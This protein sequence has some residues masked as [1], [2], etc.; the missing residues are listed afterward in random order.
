MSKILTK[1]V[2]KATLW[3]VITA[4]ILAVAVVIGCLFGFNKSATVSNSR[5]MTITVEQ[6]GFYN[7]DLREEIEEQCEKVFKKL[8]MDFTYE[9]KGEMSGDSELVYMFKKSVSATKFATA[10]DSLQEIFDT[11]YQTQGDKLEAIEVDVMGNADVE[12]IA[13][14]EK[15]FLLRGVIAGVIFAVLAFAYVSLRF[16]L[17]MGILTAGSILV[18]MALTT[19]LAVI[20]RIPVTYSAIA[21][22]AVSA[23]VTAALVLL[24]L[25]KLR[26]KAKEATADAEEALLANAPEKE[27]LTVAACGGIALVVMG[28][29]A[30]TTVRWFAVLALLG[31]IASV[32]VSL[33]FAPSVYLPL[34]KIA[35]KKAEK[36]TNYKGAKKKS[37]EKKAFVKAAPVEAKTEEVVE[38]T[39]E[40]VVEETT[41][42]VVEET[43]EEVVEETTEEVVEETTEEVVEET[44][45]EVVEEATEEVVEEKTEEQAE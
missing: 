8:D 13:S 32:F 24:T 45:E 35:D 15:N 2:K 17:Q 36:N 23:L 42:E 40:E 20:A 11:R 19:A 44:T 4:V 39:T 41:E 30:T 29:I 10:E 16:K 37:K 26:A 21:V 18:T 31:L 43:T 7:E 33:I 3:T 12:V 28:V 34:K 22:V 9:M 14:T 25:G 5:M 6:Y 1:T 27:I 38:E